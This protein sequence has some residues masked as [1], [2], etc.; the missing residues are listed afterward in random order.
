MR[1]ERSE[2]R[3]TKRLPAKPRLVINKTPEFSFSIHV[4]EEDG[5][6]KGKTLYQHCIH[7]FYLASCKVIITQCKHDIADI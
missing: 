7:A 3:S 1:F 6:A 4:R 2:Y 5:T